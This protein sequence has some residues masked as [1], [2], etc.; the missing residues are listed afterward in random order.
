MT[1]PFLFVIVPGFGSPHIHEKFRILRNNIAR[2]SQSDAF[3]KIFIRVCCYDPNF[4]TTLE[5]YENVEIE[6]IVEK[7]IVAQYIHKFATPEDVK[8]YDYVLIILDD[9]ELMDTVDM[10]Q[11]IQYQEQLRLDIISPCMTLTSKYQYRYMLHDPNQQY[12]LKVVAACEAF[13]YFMPQDAY[14]RYHSII[15]PVDNPWLWGVD[16]VLYKYHRFHIAILNSMQM[17][18]HYKNECYAMR[19]DTLPTEGYN[20]VLRKYNAQSHEF[21]NMTAVLFFVFATSG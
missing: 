14:C 11:M 9:V 10:A 3:S 15:E 21:E 19:P 7:G 4:G 20:S 17:H 6:W 16:L 18:H 1:K 12:Q 8:G 13:C 2:L 5:S